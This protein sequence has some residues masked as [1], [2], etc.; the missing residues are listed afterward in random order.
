MGFVSSEH[1]DIPEVQ[2][3]IKRVL[4]AA[5]DAGKYAGMVRF[6]SCVV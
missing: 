6:L 2:E 5:K 4:K 1:P 3:A